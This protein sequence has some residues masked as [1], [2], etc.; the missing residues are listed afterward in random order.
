MKMEYFKQNHVSFIP[1]MCGFQFRSDRENLARMIYQYYFSVSNNLKD[2]T[3]L[4]QVCFK[5]YYCKCQEFFINSHITDVI[6]LQ[7]Q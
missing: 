1:I 2:E 3:A 5:Y 7:L 4:E 6:G